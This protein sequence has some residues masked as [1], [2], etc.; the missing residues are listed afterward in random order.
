MQILAT[1]REPLRIEGEH[2]HRL[3]ALASP[4]ASLSLSAEEALRFPAAQLFA[5]RAAA[6]LDEFELSDANA[7]IV[8]DI[9]SKLEGLRWRSSWRRPASTPSECGGWRRAWTIGFRC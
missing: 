5:E 8:A 7:P 6:S 3:A 2:V 1:S 9:C 4:P